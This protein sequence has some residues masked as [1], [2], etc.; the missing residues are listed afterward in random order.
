MHLKLKGY[1]LSVLHIYTITTIALLSVGWCEPTVYPSQTSSHLAPRNDRR[2]LSHPPDRGDGLH[3][4]SRPGEESRNLPHFHY[5]ENRDGTRT[6][7]SERRPERPL[8]PR[9]VSASTDK[10]FKNRGKPKQTEQERMDT[11]LYPPKEDCSKGDTRPVIRGK[12]FITGHLETNAPSMGY[13]SDSAVSG[14]LPGIL[15]QTL[16]LLYDFWQVAT[17]MLYDRIVHYRLPQWFVM[18]YIFCL[19]SGLLLVNIKTIQL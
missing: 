7:T 6:Q 3:L 15:P 4:H 10:S 13:Q 1:G 19:L 16:L 17:K 5:M 18:V 14:K 11:S 8:R 9:M 2:G 12:L